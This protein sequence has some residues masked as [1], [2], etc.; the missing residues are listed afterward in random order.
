MRIKK[1]S[2]FP[3]FVVVATCI[4][5]NFASAVTTN[6]P[7]GTTAYLFSTLSAADGL[8]KTGQ[9]TLTVGGGTTNT[10]TGWT[11]IDAGAL[12]AAKS[13]ALGRITEGT[14]VARGASLLLSNNISIAA[15]SLF[16]SGTGIGLLG[17]L[18]NIGGTNRYQGPISLLAASQISAT[19]G[20]LALG[21]TI[22]AAG[23]ALSLSNSD[24][25]SI[26]VAGSIDGIGSTVTK[27]GN[28]TLVLQA[29]NN[30]DG[31][32]SIGAGAVRIADGGAL[33]TSAAGTDV[34]RNAALELSNNITV[35]MEPLNLSGSG[36][37]AGGALRNISGDNTYRGVI[38]NASDARI[39]SDAGT[40]S[41]SGAINANNRRLSFGG[42][43]NIAMSGAISNSSVGLRKDGTG[44]VTL[45]GVSDYSGDI[46]ID[47]GAL[48]VA[49]GS[50]IAD[51]GSVLLFSTNS[52]GTLLVS[53]SETIGGLY[54]GST[55]S[56]AK[57]NI[58]AGQ[59][60]TV[61][62]GAFNSSI[63]GAGSLVK[64]SGGNLTLG[65]NTSTYSGGTTVSSGALIVNGS[66]STGS[67]VLTVAAG[68]SLG[69]SGSVAGAATIGGVHSP[70][71]KVWTSGA[72]TSAGAQTFSNNLTYT[73][74]SSF[75]WEL[76]ANTAQARSRGIDYDGVNVE[77]N[78][79]FNGS[80]T[81]DLSFN[82][83]GSSVDWNDALW[84]VD[85]SWVLFQVSLS[86][87]REIN[88]QLNPVDWVDANGTSFSSVR[89]S[90]G[91]AFSV[92]KSGENVLLNYNA[93]PEPSTYALL[94]M[95]GA[96]V[97]W[98]ARRRN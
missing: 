46:L 27:A 45:R 98:W 70:G 61:A 49:S 88:L 12:V 19:A 42:S 8:T 47:S 40:L 21:T 89:G 58:A 53:A 28:G 57:V 55:N 92:V 81:L 91:T 25:A 22:N 24:E 5:A 4:A 97:L 60:L 82:S 67:G 63:V 18:G 78:L 44:T 56:S 15:E 11:F 26:I 33:G 39:N 65:G 64:T 6:V 43:G 93:V 96:G 73:E 75:A 52:T 36:I 68:A 17:A 35:E 90:P 77:G 34:L 41:L 54:A 7:S 80:V 9:G 10:Y 85:Q 3:L 74:L 2:Q 66:G 29:A 23:F 79:I 71:T 76:L 72:G 32:T 38:T 37:R 1:R 48:E 84:A 30:Y 86:T 31:G 95:T 20:T 16:L 62:S 69:G 51:N 94:L 59:S 50:A 87:S 13:S 83:T 14:I